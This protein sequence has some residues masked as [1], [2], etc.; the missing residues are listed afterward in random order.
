MA[1]YMASGAL[2]DLRGADP[3]SLLSEAE[4]S[5][6]KTALDRLLSSAQTSHNSFTNRI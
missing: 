5:S 2:L 3:E 4:D 6:I 1:V